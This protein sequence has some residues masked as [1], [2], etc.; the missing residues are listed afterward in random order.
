MRFKKVQIIHSVVADE[1]INDLRIART[2]F[3]NLAEASMDVSIKHMLPEIGSYTLWKKARINSVEGD[4]VNVTV[5][6]TGG[7][8]KN[9]LEIKNIIFVGV[10]TDRSNIMFHKEEITRYDFLD[11]SSNDE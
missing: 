3:E 4:K 9:Q 10:V 7:S 6:F 11:L 2:L 5:F 1:E 8:A